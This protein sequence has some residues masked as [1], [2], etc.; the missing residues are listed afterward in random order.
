VIVVP[1]LDSGNILSKNLEYLAR[2]KV[3]G[4]VM[5]ASAPIVLTSRSDPPKARVFSLALAG[6]LCRLGGCG[7]G[8]AS[9]AP[10]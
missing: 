10:G 5:G 2:A 3:A 6:L 4:I 9:K 8:D 7:A 1:D